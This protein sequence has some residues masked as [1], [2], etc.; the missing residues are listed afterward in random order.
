M[1]NKILSVVLLAM[2]L[3]SAACTA[4]ATPAATVVPTAA[5]ATT[6]VATTAAATTTPTTLTVLAAAS[7]TEPFQDIGKSFEAAHPGVTVEFSFAGSQDLAQQL[8]QGADADVFAS[9]ST[10]Y[11]D[12]AVKDNRV[13]QD[14][15]KTF[16]MNK[17]VVIYPNDNPAKITSLTDLAKP[18]IKLDLASAD[19]PVGKY[20]ITFLD[21]ASKDATYG[22]TYKDDVLKNVVSY[23]DNVKA[24]LT[25]VSL[26]EADAGIV[27]ISD[28]SA[29]YATKVQKLYIPDSLNSIASYP[30]APISDSKN[31]TLAQAFVDAVLATDGQNVLN[32]YGFF[33]AANSFMVTDALNRQVLFAKPPQRIVLVGKALFMIA[34]AIYTFPDAMDK[35]VA[36]GSTAQG[37]GDF[38]SMIDP[39]AKAKETL[40]GSTV[41]AEQ[42][43]AAN[44]DLVIMKSINQQTLGGP[45][46]ALGIPVVYVDFETPDQY[47]RDLVTL[48]Q[49]FQNETRAQEVAKYYQDKVTAITDQTSKLTDDQKPKVLVVYYNTNNNAVALNVPPLSFIQTTQVIDAGGDPVWKDA[50]LGNSWTTVTIEQIAAWNPDV[51]F[52]VAYFSPVNDVVTSLKADPQWSELKAVKDNK[53][54][55]FATDVYSWDESDTRWILGLTWEASKLHPE[56]FPNLDIKTEAQNFYQTIYGMDDTTFESKIVPLFTGDLP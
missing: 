27:Y 46:E 6:A 34:D 48:G 36:L 12:A 11:M 42:I 30:I 2:M 51:I 29:D 33:P 56:L 7:L 32:Q 45:L 22:S 28:V 25:K 17:L 4:Q 49:I 43:A 19:V 1:R 23:E 14:A 3:V 5:A 50:K 24:V 8:S 53:I 40:A 37:S 47:N 41:G 20:A 15:V 54:Y 55:G 10:S 35:V 38:V 13:S 26:G 16:A 44:P 31:A 9:A 21:N 18:G 39:N 52:V